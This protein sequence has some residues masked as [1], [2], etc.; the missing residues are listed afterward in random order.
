M[1]EKQKTFFTD[2]NINRIFKY[3]A[4][5]IVVLVVYDMVSAL[6]S[7]VTKPSAAVLSAQELEKLAE[8]AR[9][10]LLKDPE[11]VRVKQ[12]ADKV[13]LHIGDSASILRSEKGYII[14]IPDELIQNGSVKVEL[15]ENDANFS[16]TGAISSKP[17][18]NS[19]S[20]AE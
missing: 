11:Y 20:P 17:S 14:Y 18:E 1:K 2:K 12:F 6:R 13:N 5:L 10:N 9:E 8:V 15:Q 16:V 3:A 19:A 4:L 7:P